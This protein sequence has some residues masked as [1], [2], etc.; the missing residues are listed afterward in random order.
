MRTSEIF[1]L[2]EELKVFQLNEIVD[3]LLEEWDFLG[4]THVKTKVQSAVYSWLR[5]GI[6]VKVNKEPPVFALK[7]YA[8]NWKDYYSGIKTCPVCGTTFLSRR[9]K[10]DRYCSKKC[11]EK[12]KTKRRKEK[13]RERVKNYLHSADTTAINKGKMWTQREIEILRKLKEEGKSCR[14]IATE[15]GRTVYSVRWKLQKLKGG[16]YAN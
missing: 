11:Y 12:A 4:R 8:G 16:S 6:I 2:I 14:E 5:Y 10:Q 1:V 9:G 7:D 3:R 15:L 13:T